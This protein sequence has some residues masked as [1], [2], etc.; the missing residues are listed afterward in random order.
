[1]SNRPPSILTGWWD[2]SVRAFAALTARADVDRCDRDVEQLARESRIGGVL[3]RASVI[4]REAWLAS[5]SR[6]A[7]LR[8]GAALTSTSPASTWRVAGWMVAVT[9][10]TALA[11]NRLSTMPLGPLTW[12]APTALVAAGLLV[13]SA[14]APLSR[15]AADRRQGRSR[16]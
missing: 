6:A 7:A 12:V 13:M 9:G 11:L 10:A 5:W 16:S 3:H 2:L 8:L 15:A 1:M 14:A 4:T